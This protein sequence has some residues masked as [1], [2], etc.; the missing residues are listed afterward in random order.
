[1]IRPARRRLLDWI[2]DLKSVC[3]QH[4]PSV[5]GAGQLVEVEG[6]QVVEEVTVD[7]TAEDVEFGAENV[8]R[9]AVSAGRAWA[10]RQRSRPLFRGYAVSVLL[11]LPLL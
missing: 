5:G 10:W 1:M 8:E 9:V 11:L 3:D 6:D 2:L 4:F 7:L